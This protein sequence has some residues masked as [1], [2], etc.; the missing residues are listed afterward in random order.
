MLSKLM[1]TPFWDPAFIL[2]E[3]SLILLA[4]SIIEIM[5]IV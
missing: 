4:Y 5:S 2:H 1:L 3:L